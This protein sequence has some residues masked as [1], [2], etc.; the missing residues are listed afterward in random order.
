M[1]KEEKRAPKNLSLYIGVASLLLGVFCWVGITPEM[2]GDAFYRL[3]FVALPAVMFASGFL[4]GWTIKARMIDARAAAEAAVEAE[5]QKGETERERMRQEATE[6]ERKREEEKAEAEKK[7]VRELILHFTNRQ[8]TILLDAV[9]DQAVT[10][11][12]TDDYIPAMAL[13]KDGFLEELDVRKS[14]SKTWKATDFARS[15]VCRE[16][17]ELWKNLS[18]AATEDKKARHERC[19]DQ[20][21]ERFLELSFEQR[22]FALTVW[23]KGEIIENEWEI[24]NKYESGFLVAEDMG[25]GKKKYTID[26][27]YADLFTERYDECSKTVIEVLG[28]HEDD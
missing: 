17:H 20:Q 14:F 8:K 9:R 4:L 13:E 21:L 6:A 7:R 15:I 18:D 26:P 3:L 5:K 24:R 22:L 27:H 10:L 28:E 12:S 11:D 16:D 23:K 1:S 2:V 25:S 19:L